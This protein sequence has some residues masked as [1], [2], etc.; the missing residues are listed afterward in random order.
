M[1]RKATY[2]YV[3]DDVPAGESE[4]DVGTPPTFSRNLKVQGTVTGVPDSTTEV[5]TV[6]KVRT[7]IVGNQKDKMKV[8]GLFTSEN[9]RSMGFSGGS[10]EVSLGLGTY[11]FNFPSSV[12][13]KIG[14][15]PKYI[16]RYSNGSLVMYYNI[17]G[18]SRNSY[19]ASFS[20]LN[21]P[22]MYA[23]GLGNVPIS[24][25]VSRYFNDSVNVMLD[26]YGSSQ[27]FAGETSGPEF[28]VNTCQIS[29]SD[30]ARGDAVAFSA[31]VSGVNFDPAAHSIKLA[32][33]PYALVVGPSE[34]KTGRNS[35]SFRRRFGDGTSINFSYNYT[36]G[37]I[38]LRASRL[39]IPE[40]GNPS[41]T[42]V[43]LELVGVPDASWQYEIGLASTNSRGSRFR[44]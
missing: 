8:S 29:S 34:W 16:A 27:R 37:I 17:G 43:S 40:I 4:V 19:S 12:W 22:G 2:N 11:N 31:R 9:A 42:P 30:R 33:G 13:R 36:T 26:Q 3:S 21:V 6:Q 39:T 20:R 5:M 1:G 35:I 23:G 14:R 44:Y 7:T 28:F 38:R 18:S 32:V 10:R 15:R 25:D 24:L 41:R